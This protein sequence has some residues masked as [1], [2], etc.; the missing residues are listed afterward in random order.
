LSTE[1]TCLIE[2]TLVK[3]ALVHG[4]GDPGGIEQAVGAGRRTL[5]LLRR[6]AAPVAQKH[7]QVGRQFGLYF[8]ACNMSRPAAGVRLRV[9]QPPCTAGKKRGERAGPLANETNKSEE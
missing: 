9:P 3:G 7:L 4:G 2:P 6:V 8:P 1:C 5:R